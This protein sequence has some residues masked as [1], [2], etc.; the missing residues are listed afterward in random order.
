M[1]FP[2]NVLTA[3]VGIEKVE[4][5]ESK[6]KFCLLNKQNTHLILYKINITVIEIFIKS[7]K[8]YFI[9]Y[10]INISIIYLILLKLLFDFRYL[11]SFFL[12]R[13]YQF[14]SI[15]PHCLTF[16]CLRYGPTQLSTDLLM[17]FPFWELLENLE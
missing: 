17:L 9:V 4:K 12:K 6:P 14:Y 1:H 7:I 2:L 15:W 5:E 8:I 11:N 13:L 10:K 16:V 3:L